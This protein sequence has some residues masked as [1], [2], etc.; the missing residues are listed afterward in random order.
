[1]ASTRK[2]VRRP[3]P[4]RSTPVAKPS[5][6]PSG[7]R[8]MP[9]RGE[10]SSFHLVVRCTTPTTTVAARSCPSRSHIRTHR[11]SL[12]LARSRSTR[13]PALS[14]ITDSHGERGQIL[15]MVA[16]GLLVIFGVAALVFDGGI[17]LL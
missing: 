1:M 11:S 16:A 2:S 7:K 9:Y 13:R 6:R 10:T 5:G 14:L 12:F 15:V 4:D 3:D 17:M 8:H